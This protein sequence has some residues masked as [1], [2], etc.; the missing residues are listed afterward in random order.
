MDK[1]DAGQKFQKQE[2]AMDRLAYLYPF[3]PSEDRINLIDLWR[4]MARHK[5]LF[6]WILVI[7]YIAAGLYVVL[8]RP[9]YESRAVI[10]VGQV[11]QVE[12]MEQME[13]LGRL[14]GKL[15]QV[16]Q[17]QQVESISSLVQRLKLKYRTDTR[18]SLPR[19]SGVLYLDKT[20]KSVST[21]IEVV[22]QAYSPSGAHDLV[23]Q[24]V[25]EVVE[26]HKVLFE[27]YMI[28]K[29]NSLQDLSHILQGL[30]MQR[31]QLQKALEEI[32]S[33]DVS[34]TAVGMMDRAKLDIQIADLTEKLGRVQLS[35]LPIHTFPTQIRLEPIIPNH[36]VKPRVG[37]VFLL[38]TV[39]GL[40]LGASAVFFA[41]F[42][43][44]V[45]S[46]REKLR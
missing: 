19:I 20:R 38:A 23:S 6:I 9:V 1:K 14:V 12:Q 41:E 33:Q 15:G 25:N 4:T 7:S 32:S 3:Q 45:N 43:G 30:I 8:V 10:Q 24:A 16:E 22:A 44:K 21:F 35:L 11:G 5:M 17:V 46:V 37:L 18:K 39:L 2:D 29:R 13:P 27:Q 40:M 34:L 42:R 36:S 26:E 31:G 28:S